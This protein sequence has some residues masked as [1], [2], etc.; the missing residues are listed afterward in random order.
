MNLKNYFYRQYYEKLGYPAQGGGSDEFNQRNR[1]LEEHRPNAEMLSSLQLKQYFESQSNF[2]SIEITTQYPG[3]FVGSGYIHETGNEGEIKLGFFFDHTTGLP[4]VPGSSVKGVLRS[5]FP[6]FSSLLD[7]KVL[8]D[9]EQADEIQLAKADYLKVLFQ[10]IG[11]ETPDEWEEFVH[12]LELHMFEGLDISRTD[13]NDNINY[14]SICKR[15]KF[16]DAVPN[17]SNEQGRIMGMDSITPHGSDT[18]KNPIPLPFTKVLPE[19]KFCFQFLLFNSEFPKGKISSEQKRQLFNNILLDHGVGA[20]TNVGYGQFYGTREEKEEKEEIYS[21]GDKLHGVVKS[22]D[23]NGDA[24][25]YVEEI[26]RQRK[27]RKK[28]IEREGIQI[29]EEVTLVLVRERRKTKV[30]DRD[31]KVI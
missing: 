6:S 12:Q 7:K 8:P 18:L 28:D 22:F 9:T 1:I 11:I 3:L 31:L 29:G 16:F 26:D 17:Q 24:N 27:I 5:V 23:N 19:V 4:V 25:I 10:E 20:K 21:A 2:Q 30:R 15:D 13:E 14:L